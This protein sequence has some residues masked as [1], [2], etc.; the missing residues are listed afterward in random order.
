MWK[1][2]FFNYWMKRVQQQRLL[3]LFFRALSS[4]LIVLPNSLWTSASLSFSLLSVQEGLTYVLD[5]SHSSNIGG[6]QFDDKFI[7]FFTTNFTKKITK[8]PLTVC[9]STDISEKRAEAKLC[10][11]IEHT[12]RTISASLGAATLLN[13]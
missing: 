5:P 13:R 4:K 10:L 8:T 2:T 7:K 6:E 3:K 1:L 11:A 9:P 12:E